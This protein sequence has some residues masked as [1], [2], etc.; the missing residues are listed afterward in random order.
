MDHIYSQIPGFM[1]SCMRGL[2][3][4]QVRE[5]RGDAV[6][7]EVGAF[8]GASTAYMAVEII[9]SGKRIAFHTVDSWEGSAEIGHFFKDRDIYQQ[10]RAYIAQVAHAVT[11]HRM[12]ST[13]AAERFEDGSIDFCFIDAAHDY[14]NCKADIEAWLPKMKP[15]GLLAGHDY[16]NTFLGVVNAV[17]DVLGNKQDG[18]IEVEGICWLYRVPT[19]APTHTV[20]QG[21]MNESVD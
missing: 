4:S 9:N 14:D 11:V 21:A 17:E 8:L 5:V 18:D 6:F 16:N 1:T 7:V 13:E 3:L 20:N 2:Y 15:G 19:V 10:F 12:R